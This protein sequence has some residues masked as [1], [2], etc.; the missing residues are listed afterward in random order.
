MRLQ[1]DGVVLGDIK[2]INILIR[3]LNM[4]PNLLELL[5]VDRDYPGLENQGKYPHGYG[6]A[7]LSQDPQRPTLWELENTIM[8]WS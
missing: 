6:S 4:A 8:K 3:K 1:Y 2:S 5:F 7:A